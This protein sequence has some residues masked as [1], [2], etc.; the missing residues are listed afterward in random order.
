[1]TAYRETENGWEPIEPLPMSNTFD[2]ELYADGHW[3]LWRGREFIAQGQ[4]RNWFL[5][6]VAIWWASLRWAVR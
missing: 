2:A 5:R 6:T 1:M 4:H 3:E